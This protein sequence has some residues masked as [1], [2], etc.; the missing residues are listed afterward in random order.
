MSE[1]YHCDPDYVVSEDELCSRTETVWHPLLQC[2]LPNGTVLYI[3][4]CEC[5]CGGVYTEDAVVY[6]CNPDDKT[7]IPC[8]HERNLVLGRVGVQAF[9]LALAL[10][11]SLLT[12]NA[13]HEAI[14]ARVDNEIQE[15]KQT[16]SQVLPLVERFESLQKTVTSLQEV[17][18][19]LEGQLDH[20][21]DQQ[22]VQPLRSTTRA[23]HRALRLHST[24]RRSRRAKR[25]VRPRSSVRSSR[26]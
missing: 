18:A 3:L 6:V 24:T 23:G 7:Y 12:L 25:H 26:V 5:E 1:H 13:L 20:S 15:L 21:G 22:Q 2:T 9:D 10:Q 14:T 11:Q 8:V 17:V 19:S 16:V 4:A